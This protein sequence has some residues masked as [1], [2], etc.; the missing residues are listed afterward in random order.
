MIAIPNG[1]D[2]A[3]FAG[4]SVARRTGEKFRVVHTGY[5]HTSAGLRQRDQ[6]RFRRALG[7]GS[8]GV[9]ILPRS[10]FYLVEAIKTMLLRDPTLRDR[11][12]LH[13]AGVLSDTDRHVAEQVP[14]TILH[15]YLP[16]AESIALMQSA[17]L[18]FLPMQRLPKGRRSTTV[19]G[20]TYEYLASGRPMLGAVPPGDAR[21]ILER[22]G[23]AILCEPGDVEGLV[24]ALT[25]ALSEAGDS[26]TADAS[27]EAFSYS[28]LAGQVGSLIDALVRPVKAG[29]RRDRMH[30][31]EAA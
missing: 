24:A 15:G 12:E 27:A 20:K 10:H 28:A 3:D 17:D 31:P 7:G 9:D 29:G 1:Y 14:V 22:S 18:L 8:P 5:L 6:S 26:H 13:F 11:L 16:H 21:D 2:P 4:I 30:P 23:R 19:P 25:K